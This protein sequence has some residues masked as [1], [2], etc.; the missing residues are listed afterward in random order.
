M[1]APVPPALQD[2]SGGRGQCMHA[3]LSGGGGTSAC[4]QTCLE[5][6]GTSAFMQ[7]FVERGAGTGAYNADPNIDTHHA[8]YVFTQKNTHAVFCTKM[9]V[10]LSWRSTEVSWWQTHTVRP[11]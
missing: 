9:N 3:N 5:G 8:L 4:I 11:Y 6:P 10:Q 1:N 2:R 7:T